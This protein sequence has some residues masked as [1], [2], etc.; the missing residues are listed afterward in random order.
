[1]LKSLKRYIMAFCKY[2][3][4]YVASSKTEIDNIFINDYLPFAQ[5]EFV[6]VYIYGLYKCNDASAF[7]NTL[8]SFAKHLNMSEDDVI[9]AFEFW[10]EQGLVQVLN[11]HPIEVRF[12]PLKNVLNSNRLFKPDKYQTFNT[13]AQE[14]FEGK[15]TISKTEY[16]EY[17]DFLERYHMEQ[18]ALLMIMKYC[19]DSKASGVGYNYILTVARNWA[20]EGVTTSSAVEERIEALENKV[21][22][23]QELFNAVGI[24]RRAYVEE[25]ALMDKWLNDYGF[26]LDVILYLSK[27]IKKKSRFSFEKLD[28]LLT[29]YYEMKLYTITDI[30]AFEKEK[31][32]LYELAKEINKTIGVYYEVLDGEVE[33]YILKWMN[34]GFDEAV[35]TEIAFYCFKHNIRNLDGMDKTVN[36][37][38]KLGVLS[39]EALNQYINDVFKTDDEIQSILTTLGQSRN[40][41][42][43]DRE[44]YRTWKENWKMP[45]ELINYG[46]TLAKGKDS[47]MKYLSRVLSDWH[48]K[49]ISTIEEA[50]KTSPLTENTKPQQKQN[51]TGRSY[52]R[53]QMNALFDS[54][55]D[56]EI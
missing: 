55:D 3:T 15:R 44:N 9:G 54:I 7:D 23:L 39:T 31:T 29:R 30:E 13:Q 26:N 53:E 49:G 27:N 18:E 38:Y 35:L 50:K 40:V 37:F 33:N 4:E 2:S 43:I 52:T 22:Q 42:Y 12:I 24:K 14:I 19:V 8:E 47:P 41:N 11:T 21:P 1:M 6:K 5:A 34:L 56:I 20:N 17:Y 45:S 16:G 25:R 10:Q 32:K 36:K 46:V 48:N 28:G 51:F